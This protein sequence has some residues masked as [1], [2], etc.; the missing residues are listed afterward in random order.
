M[1]PQKPEDIGPLDAAALVCEIAMAVLLVF[2]GHGLAGGWPGWALGAFLAVVAIGLW[3]VWVAPKS[4]RRLENPTRL[5]VQI[6]LFVATAVY[7]AAGGLVWFGVAFAV[8]ASAVFI[9]VAVRDEP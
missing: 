5:M 9:A 1:P 6:M 8:I 7:A 3:G 4:E 2:A